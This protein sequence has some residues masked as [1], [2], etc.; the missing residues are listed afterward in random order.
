VASLSGGVCGRMGMVGEKARWWDDGFYSRCYDCS[1]L[2][3]ADRR[4]IV[5]GD[6]RPSV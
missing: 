6:E 3:L 1:N 2:G 4:S 5:N